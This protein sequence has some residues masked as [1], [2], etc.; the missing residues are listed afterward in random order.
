MD[1]Y[2]EE[3]LFPSKNIYKYTV[4]I[5]KKWSF[6]K[7]FIKYWSF[8]K[9]AKPILSKNKYDFIIVW[10]EFTAFMFAFYLS[11]KYKMKYCVN[12]RDYHFNKIFF[13]NIILK[14]SIENSAFTTISSDAF[15][16]FLPKY[17]YLMIHSLNM[18]L[19]KKIQ[20][21]E[22]L[23]DRSEIISIL[24]IGNMC[25]PKSAIKLIDQLS[26]DYRYRL[27]FA[28][29][30][31]EF[32]GDYIKLKKYKNVFQ[33]GAFPS[34]DTYK[35]LK[36][37]DVIYNINGHGSIF[38]DTLLSIKLYYS[39]YLNIPTIVY[40]GTYMAQIANK[41]GIGYEVTDDFTNM[42]DNFYEWYHT[43]DFNSI[44]QKCMLYISE[45][46]KS[47]KELYGLLEKNCF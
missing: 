38:T 28:G 41:C 23:K 43:L 24:F 40:Q 44:K 37:A 16:S 26:N 14:K 27:I 31:T 30:G 5:I 4:K 18:N 42:N 3:E 45:I 17:D 25:F 29:T 33:Y 7:K 2:G 15:R 36:M 11:R 39:I 21:T 10:N 20:P 19:L 13:V 34:E 35:Y 46:E 8:K 47:H 12:I 32:I 6:I 22:K 1:K 9:Y